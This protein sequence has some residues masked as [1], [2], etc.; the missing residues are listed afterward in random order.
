M[1]K[2]IFIDKD[3]T[4][5]RDIPYNCDPE[6]VEYLPG[7]I[8]GLKILNDKGYELFVVTNQS[9]IALNCFSENDLNLYIKSLTKELFYR[10]IQLSGFYY[11]PHH[12]FGLNPKYSISCLC[13]KP[14][15]GMMLDAVFKFGIDSAKSFMIGDVASDIEAGN[16]IGLTTVLL[17]NGVSKNL[18]QNIYCRPDISAYNFYEATKKII[19]YVK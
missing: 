7:V 8:D 2:A 19:E 1:K 10:K 3:G 16:K 18:K 14:Q 15:P 5:V 4:M 17:K 13:R 11:C 9:G 6:R 12:P